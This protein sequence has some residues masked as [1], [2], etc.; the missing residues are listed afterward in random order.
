MVIPLFVGRE[1]S[2]KALEV[3]MARDQRIFLVAQKIALQEGEV[4]TPSCLY[5]VGTIAQVLQ[6]LKLPDGTLKV[7]VEGQARAK[8]IDYR[9]AEN[10][11]EAE[12]SLFD[13][14]DQ[15]FNDAEIVEIMK[16]IRPL[17]SQFDHYVKLN[18][19]IPLEVIT[20]LAGVESPTRVVDT[21]AAHMTLK[22]EDRQ[23]LLEISELKGRIEKLLGLLESEIEFLQVE[24]K[25][26]GRV[27]GQM[28]KNQKEYYLNEQ[29]KAIQKDLIAFGIT[30]RCM[31]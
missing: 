2:V 9:D 6:L 16:W 27:K 28:E 19:K 15:D 22:I 18:K 24:K 31:R 3:A 13:Q 7:L 8:I 23:Q 20:A 12:L 5:G 30:R 11:L 10:F 14:D 25:I 1:Q 29:M 21:I 26:R 17:V 4:P